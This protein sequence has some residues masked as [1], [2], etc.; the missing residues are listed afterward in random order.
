MIKHKK[1]FSAIALGVAF[2]FGA[3]SY[4]A[5]VNTDLEVNV[6]L[7]QNGIDWT[8]DDKSCIIA[9]GYGIPVGPGMAL[10]RVAAMADARRNL[11]G[12]IDGVQIDSDTVVENLKVQ[13]DV[14]NQKISGLLKGAQVI[15]EG[16]ADDGN[17]FV[18][19]RVPLYGAN[20]SLAA[21]VLPEV[22]KTSMLQP[23]PS[24]NMNLTPLPQQEITAV[25]SSGYTG[26]I[27]DAAGMGL[28]STFSP[29]IYDTNGRAIYGASN[30]DPDFA[31]ARGMVGYTN[32]LE[33]ATSGSRAGAN[34]LVIR[35]VSLRGGASA[36]SMV[37]VVVTPED[38]DKI[39][40]ANQSSH[41]LENCAVVF[42]R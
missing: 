14:I 5:A 2:T 34:P 4:V 35:A 39:L 30:I 32:S 8:Q 37:N 6:K 22:R 10:A 29:V 40:L 41:M 12:I 33:K 3:P 20:N 24:V 23:L 11:V 18:V 36:N 25:R 17:Y 27:I 19:M 28:K 21:A 42:V 38:G 15:D 1:L 9:T 16:V 13:S 31:I 7:K 26:V